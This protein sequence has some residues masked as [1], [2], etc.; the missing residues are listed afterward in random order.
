VPSH[1]VASMSGVSVKSSSS[2]ATPA[3]ASRTNR[4]PILPVLG[5]M[6]GKAS[7]FSIREPRTWLNEVG[8]VRT[9]ETPIPSES[10]PSYSPCETT[11]AEEN[12]RR[13]QD[14]S[15]KKTATEED[16][17]FKPASQLHF[18]TGADIWCQI[19]RTLRSPLRFRNASSTCTERMHCSHSSHGVRP[20][21]LVLSR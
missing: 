11:D 3:S 5:S 20:L 18:Q 16:R 7:M 13:V 19:G 10:S 6:T 8:E 15:F 2:Q 12:G 4:R 9:G 21:R 1:L 17:I 14:R